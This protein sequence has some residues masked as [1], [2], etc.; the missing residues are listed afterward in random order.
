LSSFVL[1][2]KESAMNADR[3]TPPG[4]RAPDTPRDEEADAGAV[5]RGQRAWISPDGEVH[6]SGAGAGGGGAP[7]DFDSD[8][9][10]G[11]EGDLEPR[12]RRPSDTNDE[13]PEDRSR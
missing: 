8:P 2:A 10:S 11:A 7:E 13:S 6:G 9:A 12:Q 4:A 5:N 1:E 3:K